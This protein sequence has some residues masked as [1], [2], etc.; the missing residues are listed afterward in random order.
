LRP[1]LVPGISPINKGFKKNPYN[2]LNG[3]ISSFLNPAA[4][5]C[6]TPSGSTALTCPAPGTPGNPQLGNAPRFLANARSPRQFTFDM[7]FV[8]S[9]TIKEGY[10]LNV[11]VALN[12]AFNHQVFNGIGTHTLVGS[13]SVSGASAISSTANG[14]FGNLIGSNFGRIIRVGAEFNF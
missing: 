2:S 6:F 1:N 7:R 10:R 5:G 8:K 12:D 4:F 9:I 14:S 13:T 11:N 3:P